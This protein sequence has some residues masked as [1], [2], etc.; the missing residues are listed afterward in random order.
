MRVLVAGATGK[1]GRILIEKLQAEGHEPVA[2]VRESS[3]TSVLPDGCETRMA[4]LSDLPSG[5]A[6]GV[7]AVVFAAGSGSGTDED[8][9]RKIDRDGAK[10]LIDEAARSKIARFVMLSSK[11]ADAPEK[12]PDGMKTYLQAK[13][14]ADEHLRGAGLDYAIVR[15]VAL[16][17]DGGEGQIELSDSVD[18]EEIARAD[19]ATVLADSVG[20]R[21]V[22]NKTF[23]IA[24][25]D[26]EIEKA[27]G[28]L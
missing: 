27:L 26:T 4:D 5:V 10:A 1:T 17:D 14:D 23:E 28:T 24:K 6:D 9:T 22:S 18:G 2:M 12:G 16:T 25:G 21:A 11:G 7:D 20:S 15:P 13:H 19:V 8:M 3:D